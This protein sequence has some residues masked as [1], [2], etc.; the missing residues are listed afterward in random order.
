MF[1]YLHPG[2]AVTPWQNI[3]LLG[4][5]CRTTI[6]S[7]YAKHKGKKHKKKKKKKKKNNPSPPS[8]DLPSLGIGASLNGQ[9]PFPTD[10]WWNTDI[11]GSEVDPN[12]AT[13]INSIGLNKN[14]HPDF[15][16]F[17]DGGPIG[18]PYV[19]VSGTETKSN[20]T[21]DYDDESDHVG[22]PIPTNA[23][24]EGGEDSDGDRHILVIDRDNWV[25]Y[26]LF[27]VFKL[28]PTSWSAGSGAIFDLNSNELRPKGWTSADAAGLPI[29][30]GL[31]RYDEVVERGEINHA[32]RFTAQK[33]RKAYVTPARHWA[34]S[35]TGSQYPPMGMRVRLKADVDISGYSTNV[36]VILRALKKYGMMLADNGSDWFISGTHDERWDDEELSQIK[37]LHGR[38]FEVVKM[39]DLT[40]P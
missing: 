19:V 34:S 38:D 10:N 8:G 20:V 11:S 25:L 30:P 13:L 40:L 12:S 14:I 15:G 2:V 22:Y 6:V 32:L 3:D 37:E 24:I 26:E 31:V 4:G 17:W 1:T 35:L 23:P 28:G 7:G 21:F 29:F 9:I 27:Y 33:T 36:Q 16:T 18:I 39:I 5:K